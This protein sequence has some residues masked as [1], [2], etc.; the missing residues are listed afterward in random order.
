MQLF[1]ILRRHGWM[2]GEEL[3]KA[4]TRSKEVADKDFPD[5]IRWIRSYVISEDDGGLG[6]VC[7]YEASDPDA[8]RRHAAAVG[9]P[10]DEV[11]PV[12]DTVIVREDPE[13][14]AV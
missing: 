14:A 2:T 6:T 11:L 9:M 8:V 4:A 1:A 13:K 12:V 3:D 5:T 10:A 7:L